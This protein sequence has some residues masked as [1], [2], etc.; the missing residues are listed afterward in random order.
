MLAQVSGISL[1]I[2]IRSDLFNLYDIQEKNKLI[3]RTLTLS[4]SKPELLKFLI[5][6]V[7][8]NECLSKLKEIVAGLPG[9]RVELAMYAIFPHEVEGLPIQDWLWHSTR[10]ANGRASPRQFIL[11]LVLA[12]QAPSVQG[13]TIKAFPIFPQEALRWAMDQLSEFSF[14]ELID[15]FRVART[16]LSNCRAGKI[17]TFKLDDVSKLFGADDGP[18]SMQVHQLERLGFLERVVFEKQS[19]GVQS[20]EFR[21]PPI[22][23]RCWYVA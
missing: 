23:T 16:F 3:S 20:S 10:N 17:D 19:D 13:T 9:N 8:S 12:V 18:V 7:L 1:L 2:F 15:D 14:K 6:R 22:F 11:L 5:D 4:W 21:V